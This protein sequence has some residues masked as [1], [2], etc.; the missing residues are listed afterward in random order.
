MAGGAALVGLAGGLAL[1]RKQKRRGVLSKIPTPKLKAPD[2]DLKKL[3]PSNVSLP[4]PDQALKAIGSAASQVSE[5][6]RK[7]GQ[8][9]DDVQRASDAL[10]NKK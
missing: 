8:V 6:S 3:K 1:N 7:V 10:N 2:V 9:A 4:K 5:K